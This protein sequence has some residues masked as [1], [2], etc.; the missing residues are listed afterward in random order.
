MLIEEPPDRPITW[1]L[2]ATPIS[3]FH[4][5]YIRHRTLGFVLFE[6]VAQ[7]DAIARRLGDLDQIVS[8]GFA[9]SPAMDLRCVGYSASLQLGIGPTDASDL[10]RRMREF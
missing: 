3:F 6:A 4:M 10:K 8:A 9:F 7:H 5:K 2:P 1:D